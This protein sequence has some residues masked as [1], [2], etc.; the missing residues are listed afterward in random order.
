MY[1]LHRHSKS[2]RKYKNRPW[3]FNFD[4]YFTEKT[5]IA[6]PLPLSLKDHEKADIMVERNRILTKVKEYI[7]KELDPAKVNFHDRRKEDF[8]KTKSITEIFQK[9]E[10]QKY[11]M[12]IYCQIQVMMIMCCP[13][14]DHQNHVL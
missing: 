7:D 8:V 3:R 9:L 5:I 1:Q 6:K 14:K 2:Y 11:I 10:Y 4:R 12:R 13:C